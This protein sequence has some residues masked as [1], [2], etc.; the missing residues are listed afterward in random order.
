ML[1]TVTPIIFVDDIEPCL[2]FWTGLEFAVTAE[3]PHGDQLGFVILSGHGREVM[4]QSWASIAEDL[5]PLAAP[6]RQSAT[7]L[8]VKVRDLEAV[9]TKLGDIE[10][11]VPERTT[12]YGAREL[13]I[14]APCGTVVGF[15]KHDAE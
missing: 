4:Y 11:I 1:E 12:F 5:P 13:W 9:K 15:A 8:Y 14:R 7:T 2:S 6:P 3:V 10:P